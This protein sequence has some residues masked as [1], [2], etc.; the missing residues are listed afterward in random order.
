MRAHVDYDTSQTE[1]TGRIDGEL[2]GVRIPRGTRK[3]G[4]CAVLSVSFPTHFEPRR[5]AGSM[6]T[7]DEMY[8]EAV[9]SRTRQPGWGDREAP[10]RSWRSTRSTCSRTR[11]WRST[12]RRSAPEEAIQHA[13]RVTELEPD[14][15]FSFTQLSVIFQ[16]CGKIPEAETAMYRARRDERSPHRTERP[17]PFTVR[18]SRL[19]VP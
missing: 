2:T 5:E 16:R 9:R 18:I 7:P 11:R 17:S 12:C 10:E 19:T 1:E 4:N 8:D 15:P 3:I 6:A 13:I 14:D